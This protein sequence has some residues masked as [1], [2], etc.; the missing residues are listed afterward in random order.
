MSFSNANLLLQLY[1]GLSNTDFTPSNSLLIRSRSPSSTH[2]SPVPGNS[3]TCFDGMVIDDENA[4]RSSESPTTLGLITSAVSRP[5]GLS[6][7]GLASTAHVTDMRELSISINRF[8]GPDNADSLSRSKGGEQ[9]VLEHLLSADGA[10][11]LS[12]GKHY[13][14]RRSEET[15]EHFVFIAVD[16]N[17]IFAGTQSLTNEITVRNRD[18]KRENLLR[19]SVVSRCL[20]EQICSKR[21]GWRDIRVQ[22]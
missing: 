22:F 4:S 8:F 15:P 13:L 11:T 7:T 5:V 14:V 12:L 21:Q 19:L 17:Y 10:R 16:E 3:T 2:P 9:P 20:A 18:F 1:N 6:S